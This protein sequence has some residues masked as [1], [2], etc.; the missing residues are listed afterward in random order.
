MGI[1]PISSGVGSGDQPTKVLREWPCP[2]GKKAIHIVQ[3]A[4]GEGNDRYL[5]VFHF[6]VNCNKPPVTLA[7]GSTEAEAFE[8]EKIFLENQT[9]EYAERRELEI[10]RRK[11]EINNPGH[12]KRAMGTRSII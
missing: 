7:S 8:Q 6:P 12:P 1:Y 11:E 4:D 10:Q 2:G 9:K 5:I 3:N